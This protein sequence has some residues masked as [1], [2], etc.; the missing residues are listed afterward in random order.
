ISAVSKWVIPAS[1][2]AWTT[3]ALASLSIRIPKLLHPTPTTET[4]GPPTPMGRCFT[5]LSSCWAPGPCPA[6][7]RAGRP[8]ATAPPDCQLQGPDTEQAVRADEPNARPGVDAV[9]AGRRWP[10]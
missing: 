9:P 10:R 2:H 8:G 4:R 3:A 1:R 7:Y 5:E 6:N